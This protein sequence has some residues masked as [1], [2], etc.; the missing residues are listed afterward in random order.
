MGSIHL[1]DMKS[2]PDSAKENFCQNWVLEKTRNRFSAI[3]L[4]H[5][6]K[7]DVKGMGGVV[8]KEIP[9]ALKW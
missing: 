5:P 7:Q 2:L 3:P 8:L 4:D 9:I 6:Y 1:R